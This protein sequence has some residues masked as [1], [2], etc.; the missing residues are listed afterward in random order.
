M[1]KEEKFDIYELIR[2]QAAHDLLNETDLYF[3][4]KVCRW[5]SH[6]FHTPLHLVTSGNVLTWD[7]I[8][9]HYYE[10]HYEKLKHNDLLRLTKDYLPEIAKEEEEAE[11][12]FLKRL[13]EADKLKKQSLKKSPKSPLPQITPPQTSEIMTKVFDV[14]ESEEQ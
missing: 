7:E 12:D 8:L 13:I 9:Q 4:R 3:H 1:D 5:Y 14:D 11:D 10:F 2:L 6:Q